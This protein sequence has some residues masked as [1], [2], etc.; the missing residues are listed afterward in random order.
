LIANC[1]ASLSKLGAIIN[2]PRRKI[3]AIVR[4]TNTAPKGL[5]GIIWSDT[6]P[7]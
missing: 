5:I 2:I 3:N 4:E 1:S 7:K 6:I